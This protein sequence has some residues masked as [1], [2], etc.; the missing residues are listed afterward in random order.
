MKSWLTKKKSTELKWKVEMQVNWKFNCLVK[1][2]TNSIKF[3]YSTIQTPDYLLFS[4]YHSF[5]DV[6]PVNGRSTKF[7]F[8]SFFLCWKNHFC[9][10]KFYLLNF[11]SALSFSFSTSLSPQNCLFS[12]AVAMSIEALFPSISLS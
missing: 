10:L 11:L 1:L 4:Q 2:T 6:K 12:A 5:L 8:S 7:I 9:K 3:T